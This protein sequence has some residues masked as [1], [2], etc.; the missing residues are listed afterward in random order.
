MDR[1]ACYVP[2]ELCIQSCSVRIAWRVAPYYTAVAAFQIPVDKL[3][4]TGGQKRCGDEHDILVLFPFNAFQI[5]KIDAV[6]RLTS[7]MHRKNRL[8]ER[9]G[10]KLP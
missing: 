3:L 2:Y 5:L 7:L 4:L 6:E 10:T 9:Q 1:Q 8:E